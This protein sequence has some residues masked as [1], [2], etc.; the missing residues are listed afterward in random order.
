MSTITGMRPEEIE[1]KSYQ[2]IE[3]RVPHHS[4]TPQEWAIVKRMIHAT[5]DFDLADKVRFHPNAITEGIKALRRGA[6]IITDTKMVK[7][8]IARISLQNYK[9][10]IL[11]AISQR[12]VIGEARASGRTRASVAMRKL[13]SF[14][15]GSIVA[16]GN[17]PTALVEILAL[18][19]QGALTPAL[20]IGVPVGLVGAKESKNMLMEQSIPYITVQGEKGGSPLA[21]SII[22]SLALLTLEGSDG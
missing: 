4:F 3:E 9:T 1:K 2:L 7:V 14:L 18:S 21:V 12:K 5:A 22:N 17:A 19:R 6:P 11:C 13:S 16:I 15:E 20:I 10:K 8:G